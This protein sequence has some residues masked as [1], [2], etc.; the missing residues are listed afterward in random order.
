[1]DINAN[2]FDVGKNESGLFQVEEGI[3]H[4]KQGKLVDIYTEEYGKKLLERSFG[5]SAVEQFEKYHEYRYIL[6]G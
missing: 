5:K 4:Y 6:L 3:A 2:P 1:M